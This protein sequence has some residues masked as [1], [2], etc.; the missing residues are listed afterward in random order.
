MLP[1]SK[2]TLRFEMDDREDCLYDSDVEGGD[3]DVS[4]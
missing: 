3:L 1:T 4:S 2:V